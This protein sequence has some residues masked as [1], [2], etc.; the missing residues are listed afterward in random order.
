VTSI[1]FLDDAQF[2]VTTN[3]S[4]LR[5]YSLDDYKL[6]TKFKGTKCEKYPIRSSFSHNYMHIIC[7]SEK[8]D[9]IIWNLEPMNQRANSNRNS[10][11]ESFKIG[12][13]ATCCIFAPLRIVQQTQE[14]YTNQSVD[15]IISHIVLAAGDKRLRIYYN[16]YVN[17]R[18]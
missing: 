1:D 15:I 6:R 7:G 5:L 17:Q 10:S 12:N 11:L 14:Y 2:L 9:V 3:D 13:L 8:G 4:R 16:Q 18:M